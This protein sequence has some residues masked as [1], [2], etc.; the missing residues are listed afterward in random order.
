MIKPFCSLNLKVQHQVPVG[1]RPAGTGRWSVCVHACVCVFCISLYYTFMTDV[2][3]SSSIFPTA[4]LPPQVIP[5]EAGLN[6]SSLIPPPLHIQLLLRLSLPPPFS[7]QL[8][9]LIA[10][11]LLDTNQPRPSGQ[12]RA[13][14]APPS[15][16]SAPPPQQPPSL[17]SSPMSG[18]GIRER[19][20]KGILKNHLLMSMIRY[21]QS[22]KW[23]KNLPLVFFLKHS[24]FNSR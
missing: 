10:A 19:R 11:T 15:L 24:C 18:L 1:H 9:S 22:L 7:S 23:R 2:I 4:P 5:L 6:P 14:R 13:P 21:P 12:S 16:P 8:T 20:T 17:P 3:S